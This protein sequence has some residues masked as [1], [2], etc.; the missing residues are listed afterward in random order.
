MPVLQILAALHP[1]KRQILLE[2][3][4][5]K[6]H[7]VLKDCVKLVLKEGKKVASPAQQK[8]LRQCLLKNS[9]QV[10][11][12]CGQSKKQQKK[13]LVHMGGGLIGLILSYAIPLLVSQL[14]PKK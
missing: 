10:K 12:V 8:T 3:C 6:T 2:H 4:D 7:A 13:A 1:I 14:I 9:A 11:R 5:D